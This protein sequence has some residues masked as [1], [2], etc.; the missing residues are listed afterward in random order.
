MYLFL[1]VLHVFV[2][3]V[4]ILVILMQA[5]RGGGVSEIFGGSATKTIFGTSVTSFLTKA[6]AACA[7]L[8]IITS[9]SLAVL[10]SRR[11]RSLMESKGAQSIEFEGEVEGGGDVSQDVIPVEVGTEPIESESE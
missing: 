10:S 3:M 7:V 1:M 11:S 5:G 8:F 6:T 2:S 4:L 9:L